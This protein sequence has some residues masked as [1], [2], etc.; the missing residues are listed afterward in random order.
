MIVIG[1]TGSVGTGKTETSNIFRRRKIPVFDSDYE[2]KLLYKNHNVLN[3]IKKDFPTAFKDNVLIKEKL[4]KLVFEDNKKLLRLEKIIYKF[5]NIKRYSWIRRQ[6]RN[7]KKIVVFDVPL[8]F[9]KESSKKY[10]KTVVVTCSEKVQKKRVL[11][12]KGWDEKRLALTKQNQLED[13]K[14]KRLA[15]FVIYS[16][17]GKRYVN[18]MVYNL[19]NKSYTAKIRS[20][21]MIIFNFKK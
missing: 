16:D 17:R 20:K 12:R 3:I 9:E 5:L 6:F 15:D 2:V 8:L 7:R 11:K 4:T 14:K 21:N 18:N 10:D 19:L 13:K 1:I